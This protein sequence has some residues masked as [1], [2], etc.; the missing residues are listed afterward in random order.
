MRPA[1]RF[2]AVLLAV[3][4]VALSAE[5]PSGSSAGQPSHVVT[6][7][8]GF[9]VVLLSAKLG[10]EAVE[11]LGQPAVLGELAAGIVIGNLALVG[12]P[13]FEGFKHSASLE[14][15]A[16]M[17]VILLLFQV[18][19]ESHMAELLAVGASAMVVANI[20]VILPMVLGY[21]VSQ[22]FLTAEPWY[23]HLF[24]GAT[25]AATSV[26]ITA[27]VL[28][29]LRKTETKEARIVL[30]AAVVDDVLGLIVLA[31]VSGMV[32]S[33]SSGASGG[34]ALGPV[35]MIVLKSAAFLAGAVIL[36]RLIHVNALRIASFFRVEGIT[37]ALAICFCFGLAALAGWAGL[38]PIVGAFA[39]G[40]VLEDDDYE[41]FH[42]RGVKPIEELIRPIAAIFVPV[43]FV[44][45]GLKVDL[46]AFG[47]L[48]VL[49]LAAALTVAAVLG[50]QI[51]ALGVLDKGVDRLA[52]GIGMIPRGEVG[53]IFTGM[54]ASLMVAGQPVFNAN[55]VS[56]MVVMVMLTTVMTPP[57]LKWAFTRGR[58]PSIA[59]SS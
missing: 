25:L 32:T 2:L 21:G 52:V 47:S 26:G 8:A 19:L 30:G 17:G 1:L 14:L 4:A 6:V 34:L 20:G 33:V 53:L 58:Q 31:V 16:E 3:A 50:K 22:V 23:V 56:A 27:R 18:G 49:G 10:G 35:A 55:M 28:R 43:F 51:C 13:W 45:M 11:R 41:I 37:L 29:D 46:R 7:L 24:A 48:D 40:L 5:A 38:A 15:F 54:G 9:I 59:S 42:K 12:L 39:A 44:M 57:L 36:G